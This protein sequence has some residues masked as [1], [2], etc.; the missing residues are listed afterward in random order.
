MAPPLISVGRPSY[1]PRAHAVRPAAAV[2]G[3]GRERAALISVGSVFGMPCCRRGDLNESW[4][5]G[6][7]FSFFLSFFLSFFSCF[8]SFI[9]S[10]FSFFSFFFLSFFLS[11]LLSFFPDGGNGPANRRIGNR[12]RG[13]LL[14]VSR[15][16]H[17]CPPQSNIIILLWQR[18]KKPS[19][20]RFVV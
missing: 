14:G 7:F 2:A 10:F 1:L 15:D 20:M 16:V 8:L 13:F 3:Q 18:E 19:F 9:H 5:L 6:S 12:C 11:F 4:P 17:G